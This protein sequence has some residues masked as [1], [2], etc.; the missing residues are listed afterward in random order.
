MLVIKIEV[1]LI[2]GS[3]AVLIIVII[4]SKVESAGFLGTAC[5]S[6]M[7]SLLRETTTFLAIQPVNHDIMFS[8]LSLS[9]ELVAVVIPP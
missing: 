5:M 9:R 8:A 7:I 3:T 2:A 1:A 6:E 4:S